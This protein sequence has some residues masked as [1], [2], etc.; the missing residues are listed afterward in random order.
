TPTPTQLITSFIYQCYDPRKAE[1]VVEVVERFSNFSQVYI[2][3]WIFD[4]WQSKIEKTKQIVSSLSDAGTEVWAL[5][6]WGYGTPKARD[7]PMF[8]IAIDPSVRNGV[9]S[10]LDSRFTS[11]WEQT[12]IRQ[13]VVGAILWDELPA[14]FA[15]NDFSK[16]SR[17]NDAYR[18]ETGKD[19]VDGDPD[20]YAWCAKKNA[21]AINLVA[22]R[23]KSHG[24]R[25]AFETQAV[26]YSPIARS[27]VTPAAYQDLDVRYIDPSDVD[28]AII[29]FYASL[30]LGGNRTT[31]QLMGITNSIIVESKGLIPSGV[32]LNWLVASHHYY[33]SWMT[34]YPQYAPEPTLEM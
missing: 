5:L 8:A 13:K 23:I 19:M 22:A 20:L 18:A 3:D 27:L 12:V 10:E 1:T 32:D 4:R 29:N 33:S 14:G 21:E 31:A 24:L 7:L 28:V 26:T 30:D 17:Y 2:D 34:N 16:I 15:Y 9:Y 6:Q 25:S 11:G